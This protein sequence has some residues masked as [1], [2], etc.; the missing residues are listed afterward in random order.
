MKRL[1]PL[2]L[3]LSACVTPQKS[4]PKPVDDAEMRAIIRTLASDDMEGRRAGTPGAEKAAAYIAERFRSAGLTAPRG[5]FLQPFT[6]DRKPTNL[7]PA[8]AKL[9]A[10]Q[11]YFQEQINKQGPFTAYN[12]V[13]VAVL[14]PVIDSF[15]R[16]VERI[17]PE[18]RSVL[19][20]S[21]DPAALVT[22]LAAEEAVRRTV[23]RSLGMIC[24]SIG[25]ALASRRDAASVAEADP[26][27]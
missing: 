23:A 1:L 2:F 12:V 3:A 27:H 22:P 9:P 6:I 5:G 24:G 26:Y 13:G 11:R 14:L 8:T 20:R 21:L 17:L 25:E 10:G 7:P 19:T 16:V 18:R 4:P 15:T